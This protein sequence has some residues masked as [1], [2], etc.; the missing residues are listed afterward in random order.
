MARAKP[1]Y[2]PSPRI[3]DEFQTATLLGMSVNSLSSKRRA[4]EAKGL[5][6]Q[7]PDLGGRDAAAIK[8]WLDDRSGITI[9]KIEDNHQDPDHDLDER[10]EAFA[11]G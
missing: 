2:V 4:L 9:G 10:L 5:P 11:N 3:Y 8:R 1:N 7:D 6:R